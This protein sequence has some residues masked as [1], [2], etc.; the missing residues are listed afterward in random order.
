MNKVL[1]FKVGIKG[2][3]NKIY[4]S[5][6]S[7][8]N[9][10]LMDLCCI[11]LSS[12][13]LYSNETFI[14]KH[15]SN[16]YDSVN[17]IYDNDLYKSTM[18]IKLKDLIFDEK[19][20]ILEYNPEQK[21]TFIITYLETQNIVPNPREYPKIIAGAGLALDYI[22]SDELISIVEETDKLGHSIYNYY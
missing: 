8:D 5:I 18:S 14:V 10:T 20:L 13:D 15:Q 17:S 1:T 2:L 16:Q 3:E 4:R 22:S 12:F 11:I 21:I 19:E 6:E 7:T 9:S